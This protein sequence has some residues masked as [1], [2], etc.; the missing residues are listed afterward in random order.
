MADAENPI[1][2]PVATSA[3]PP[4]AEKPLTVALVVSELRPGGAARVVVNL[5]N[6]LGKFGH[7]PVV[8]CLS[9]G[10]E[11]SGEAVAQGA[12]LEVLKEGG[13]GDFGVIRRLAKLLRHVKPDVIHVH[14]RSSLPY[15]CLAN[16]WSLR[17]PVV[18]SGHGFVQE[19]ESRSRLRDR[20]VGRGLDAITAVCESA[21]RQYATI[22]NW[23]RQVDIVTPGVPPQP[24][25]PAQRKRLRD[26][27]GLNG[28]MFAF[29]AVGD[30]KPEK[31]FEDLL[32]A[33]AALRQRGGHVP[34]T[35][36]VV[37]SAVDVSYAR[38]LEE[39]RERLGLGDRVRFLGHQRDTQTHY[40]AADAFVLSSRQEELPMVLLEAL[41]SELPVVA[42]RTAVVPAV[43]EDGS[44]G[45]LVPPEAPEALATAM[46]RLME[47]APLRRQLATAGAERVRTD[48]ASDRM[49]RNYIAVFNRILLSSRPAK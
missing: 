2:Q 22:F 10:G 38:S 31:G 14:D 3:S 43:V 20:L 41:A 28:E 6:A 34:F 33:T 1:E 8:I 44:S 37:G 29:L 18:F 45:L 42:T 7:C 15:V 49:T 47:D 19:N 24:R 9:R 11:L 46:V 35:V 26:I 16:R 39:L 23:S 21:A 17:R 13:G 48:F 32:A 4:G 25:V 12:L 5:V 30:L 36:L 27:L 40:W